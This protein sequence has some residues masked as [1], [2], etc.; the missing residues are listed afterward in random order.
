MDVLGFFFFGLDSLPSSSEI[1]TAIV[2]FQITSLEL[3]S[4]SLISSLEDDLTI[5]VKSGQLGCFVDPKVTKL[6]Q[7][8]LERSL[9]PDVAGFMGMCEFPRV[10]GHFFP[11]IHRFMI[12]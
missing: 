1:P 9:V 4:T 5:R 2:F 6:V 10:F 12:E 11:V 3:Q 7:T 8:G